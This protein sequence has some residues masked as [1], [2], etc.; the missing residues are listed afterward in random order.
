MPYASKPTLTRKGTVA[1]LRLWAFAMRADPLL[2]RDFLLLPTFPVPPDQG[3]N[4]FVD[5]VGLA[6]SSPCDTPRFQLLVLP[7]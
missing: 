3:A 7:F 2:E 6:G 5:T 1:A 4:I